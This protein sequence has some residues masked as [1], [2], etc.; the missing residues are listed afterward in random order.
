[1]PKIKIDIGITIPKNR[2]GALHRSLF[3]M[4]RY[5]LKRDPG[6]PPWPVDLYIRKYLYEVGSYLPE[7]SFGPPDTIKD[8]RL[9]V[10][11]L[12]D[13]IEKACRNFPG[14][15]QEPT[16]FPFNCTGTVRKDPR[17]TVRKEDEHA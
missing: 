10:D 7:A 8:A 1:M 13:A 6:P 2:V 11:Q 14:T 9:S 17:S 4:Y 3:R 12:F 16:H 5:T 15:L